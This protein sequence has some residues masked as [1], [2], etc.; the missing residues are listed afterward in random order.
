MTN[1]SGVSLIALAIPTRR[2]RGHGGSSMTR[3]A[4]TSIT[5]IAPIWPKNTV[6]RNG[7]VH[8]ASAHATGPTHDETRT[9]HNR[10]VAH[11]VAAVATASSEPAM[12]IGGRRS[13]HSRIAAMGG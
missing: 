5:K 4:T 12:S 10:T 13:G 7:T 2:P 1:T 6:V 3:S 11:A 9:P 8:I